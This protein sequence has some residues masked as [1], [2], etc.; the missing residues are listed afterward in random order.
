MKRLSILLLAILLS[1]I[2][3]AQLGNT[4]NC[5]LY[6]NS[7]I[8]KFISGEY[9]KAVNN[10]DAAKKC[11]ADK[12]NESL[13][14]Y[15][16]KATACLDYKELGDYNFENENYHQAILYYNQILSINPNDEN[17][18]KKCKYCL[19]K[20][21]PQENMALVESGVF[22][23]GSNLGEA[24]EKPEH[25]VSI[26]SFYI[27]KYETTN[28]E[29]SIFLNLKNIGLDSAKQLIELNETDCKIE[30]ING[31]YKPVTGY[32]DFPVVEVN[33]YG[34]NAY[35]QWLGKRLPTEA[36]WEFAAKGGNNTRNTKFCGANIPDSIAVF[37]DNSNLNINI[38]GSKLPN[39]LGI[40]DMSG[41]VWEWCSDWYMQN[42]YFMSPYENPQV[43]NDTDYKVLKGGGCSSLETNLRPQ[44]RNYYFPDE[45]QKS[46]GFRC[47]KNA[48]N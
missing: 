25:E 47:V 26:S 10:L 37:R 14:E 6:I 4:N 9:S 30:Y 16:F 1:V 2:S 45:A 11:T 22:V 31:W 33:W 40:Y 24:N 38:I 44:Y 12:Q 23:M 27:D 15:I 18:K 39:E 17:C 36:E 29:F 32:E 20:I 35:A 5:S 13:D 21:I 43:I 48:T 8:S 7:G 34:A 28:L 41:N 3:F 19:E 46:F 42:F